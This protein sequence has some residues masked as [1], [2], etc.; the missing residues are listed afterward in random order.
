MPEVVNES[1]SGICLAF[2]EP[3]ALAAG[4]QLTLTH[5]GQTR[6]AVVCRVGQTQ[7]GQFEVGFRWLDASPS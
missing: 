1:A 2:D 4:Q 7:T 3:L 5:D 6:V